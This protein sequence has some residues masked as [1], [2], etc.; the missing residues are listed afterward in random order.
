MIMDLSKLD[1][2]TTDIDILYLYDVG[3]FSYYIKFDWNEEHSEDVRKMFE[4]YKNPFKIAARSSM[5]RMI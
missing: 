5:S 4:I 3:G 2:K 1:D